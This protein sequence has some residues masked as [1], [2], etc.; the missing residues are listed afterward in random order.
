MCSFNS[1]LLALL[2]AGFLGVSSSAQTPDSETE[3]E[4]LTSRMESLNKRALAGDTKAQL[5]IGLAYEFGDGVTK[6]P[7]KAM[8]WYHIAADRGD[9][10]AQTDLG[11]FYES[12]ANGP[13]DPAEAAKWYIRAAVAGLTRAKFNLGVLYLTGTGVQR[14]YSEAAHW[15]GEAAD[16]GCPSALVSMSYLYANG[17]GV[18]RDSQKAADLNRKAAKNHNHQTLCMRLNPT[19][20][21]GVTAAD[22]QNQRSTP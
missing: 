5:Q 3:P 16:D 7:D 13:K 19:T 20:R 18:T 17:V 4:K 15:I 2:L 12:G 11:Y 14:N 10:V 9:P 6:N 22:L 8:H 21:G 1:V